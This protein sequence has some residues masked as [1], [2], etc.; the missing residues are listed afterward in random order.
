MKEIYFEIKIYG[1]STTHTEDEL[2]D[3]IYELLSDKAEPYSVE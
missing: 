3:L 2:I 1:K